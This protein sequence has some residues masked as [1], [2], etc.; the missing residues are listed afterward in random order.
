MDR[1]SD[2]ERTAN[3]VSEFPQL[4]WF[5]VPNQGKSEGICAFF[6]QGLGQ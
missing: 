2:S 6:A 5:C 3:F 1:V 4:Q